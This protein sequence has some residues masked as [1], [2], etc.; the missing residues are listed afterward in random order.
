M[1]PDE[2]LKRPRYFLAVHKCAYLLAISERIYGTDLQVLV[3]AIS[4]L[5]QT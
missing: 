4:V 3:E 2:V 5:F 1:F